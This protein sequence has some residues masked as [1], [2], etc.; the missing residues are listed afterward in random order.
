M[1]KSPKKTPKKRPQDDAATVKETATEDSKVKEEVDE[2]DGGNSEPSLL[3]SDDPV[4]KDFQDAYPEV[5]KVSIQLFT[6]PSAIMTV[7]AAFRDYDDQDDFQDILRTH[8]G[9]ILSMVDKG[10]FSLEAFPR[11]HRPLPPASGHVDSSPSAKGIAV[12]FANLTKLSEKEI[13]KGFETANSGS[14]LTQKWG[15][16]HQQCFEKL[17]TRAMSGTG[18]S[19][20]ESFLLSLDGVA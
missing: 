1:P 18:V 19:A 4:L 12:T 17:Y 13:G 11:V 16:Q 20:A 8:T 2:E 14:L 3:V 15:I 5:F 7:I 6:G 9:M 10:D